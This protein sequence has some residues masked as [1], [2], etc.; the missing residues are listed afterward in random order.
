MKNV[1]RKYKEYFWWND[2]AD[3]KYKNKKKEKNNIFSFKIMFS[4]KSKFFKYK[5]N[6]LIFEYIQDSNIRIINK[7]LFYEEKNK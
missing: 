1:W 5:W 7:W 4:S 6:Y 3:S 2:S